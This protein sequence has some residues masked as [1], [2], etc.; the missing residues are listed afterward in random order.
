MRH[1]VKLSIVIATWNAREIMLRCLKAIASY[2]PSCP[3]EIIVVDNGSQ[4]G[5]AEAIGSQYS[6]VILLRNATNLGYARANNWGIRLARGQY[7]LLLNDDTEVQQGSLDHLVKFMDHNPKLGIVTC[8]TIHPDGSLQYPARC[9]PGIWEA[10][11][12]G[13][14]L[15][16]FLPQRVRARLLRGG[17]WKHDTPAVVDWLIGAALMVRASAVAEV[18]PLSEALFIYGEDMEYCHRARRARWK[19]GFT[20]GA[21]IIHLGS[22]RSISE[23]GLSKTR[24]LIADAKYFYYQQWHGPFACMIYRLLNALALALRLVLIETGRYNAMY[25]DIGLMRYRYR[26][27]FLHHLKSLL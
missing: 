24:R 2:P 4:D 16:R 15:G 26:G 18:G 11:L 7:L 12:D 1:E 25:D 10:I 20:P 6:D 14:W 9:F 22:N 3:W 17:H 23:W 27:E 8:H 5:T 13:L 19:I 21:R